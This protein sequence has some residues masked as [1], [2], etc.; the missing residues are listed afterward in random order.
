MTVFLLPF[1]LLCAAYGQQQPVMLRY[2]LPEGS[3]WTFEQEASVQQRMS[4]LGGDETEVELKTRLPLRC[5]LHRA[6]AD[7]LVVVQTMDSVAL[8]I[9][10]P[11][12]LDTVI[13]S[14]TGRRITVTFTPSGE[15]LSQKTE[16]LDSAFSVSDWFH[17]RPLWLVSFP[18]KAVAPGDQWEWSKRDTSESDAQ[19]SR[20]TRYTLEAVVDT[21]G[22][23]CARIRSETWLEGRMPLQ[24]GSTQSEA[25]KGTHQYQITGT[26]I[27]YVELATGLPVLAL[28]RMDHE[29]S[30]AMTGQIEFLGSLEMTMQVQLRRR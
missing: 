27:T 2:S 3:S 26:G 25:L 7:T 17:S 9:V 12:P 10:S 13:S 8:S 28:M 19:E 1:L 21:L 5:K 29:G 18:G 20:R 30:L 24:F 15:L 22:Y 16:I 14:P 23:R 11:P 6:A 4:F